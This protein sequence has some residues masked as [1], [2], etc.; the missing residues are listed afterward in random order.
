VV[1]VTVTVRVNSS[2]LP[3]EIELDDAALAAIAAAVTVT[4]KH[5]PEPEYLDTRQAA[6]RLGI[7]V[8]ALEK[9]KQRGRLPYTQE[10]PGHKVWFARRDLDA[11]QP[12]HPE[13]KE[14]R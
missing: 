7:S 3:V 13:R 14:A 12:N 9:L 5:E 11:W 4:V 10:A 1:A 2:P 6:A 8:P